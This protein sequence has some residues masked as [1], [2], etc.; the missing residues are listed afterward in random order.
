MG[1]KSLPRNLSVSLTKAQIY[2]YQRILLVSEKGTDTKMQQ[3]KEKRVGGRVESQKIRT[4]RSQ[5]F[6]AS[7]IP[8]PI[9]GPIFLTSRVRL[10]ARGDHKVVLYRERGKRERKRG[11]GK[12]GNIKIKGG[13]DS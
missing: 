5:Q 3:E 12:T 4:V 11:E 1:P 9:P 13:R 8:R 2:F 10:S 6:L 7:L